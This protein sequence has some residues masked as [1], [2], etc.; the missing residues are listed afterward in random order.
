MFEIQIFD[1][2]EASCL[3][4]MNE[5]MQREL[6]AAGEVYPSMQAPMCERKGVRTT[7]GI[8]RSVASD[9]LAV[10]LKFFLLGYPDGLSLV[11][12]KRGSHRCRFVNRKDV[13]LF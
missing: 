10:C 8:K 3:R 13:R 11:G 5:A 6:K 2:S 1:R 9:V 4:E 7:L 12:S